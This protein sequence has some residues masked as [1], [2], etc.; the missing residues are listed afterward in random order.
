MCTWM[1]A[2]QPHLMLVQETHWTEA[3]EFEQGSYR[4]ISSGGT[5]RC[6]G[7]LLAVHSKLASPSHI[8]YNEWIPGRLLHVRVKL[9]L[10]TWDIINVYQVPWRREDSAEKNVRNRKPVWK[11]LEALLSSLPHRNGLLIGGDFNTVLP[12]DNIITGPRFYTPDRPETDA[13]QFH[14]LCTLYSLVA[15]NTHTGHCPTYTS[16]QGNSVIDYLLTRGPQAGHARPRT[17]V[18]PVPIGDW[19]G[20]GKHLMLRTQLQAHTWRYRERQTP[21]LAKWDE[22]AL[23]HATTQNTHESQCWAANM[24]TI[25]T[26]TD[27]RSAL[28]QALSALTAQHFPRAARQSSS[29]PWQTCQVRQSIRRLWQARAAL[30][31]LDT[32]TDLASIFRYWKHSAAVAACSRDCKRAGRQARK[33]KLLRAIDEAEQAK[34]QGDLRG[35]YQVVKRLAPKQTHQRVQLRSPAGMMLN[36]EEGLQALIKYGKSTFCREPRETVSFPLSAPLHISLEDLQQ[37]LCALKPN[38][39]VP[40]NSAPVSAFQAGGDMLLPTLLQHLQRAWRPGLEPKLDRS[41]SS[42]W[43]VWIPKPGKSPTRPEHLRPLALMT[44]EAKLIATLLKHKLQPYVTTFLLDTPQFAYTSNRNIYH[45]LAKVLGHCR[46]VRE[47]TQAYTESIQRR[48]DGTCK[49]AGGSGFG[50]LQLALD[51]SKAFEAV[52]QPLQA[53]VLSL[54][55]STKY[56]VSSGAAQ[57]TLHTSNGIRQGCPLS[58]LLWSLASGWLWKTL[59]QHMTAEGLKGL[60]LYADDHHFGLTFHD[61]K[62]L[63]AAIKQ[64]GVL[65]AVLRDA[66]LDVNAQKSVALLEVRGRALRKAA[67]QCQGRSPTGPYLRIPNPNNPTGKVDCIPLHTTAVYLGVVISYKN[68]ED[69]TVRRNIRKAQH[70]YHQ[71]RKLLNGHHSLTQHTRLRLWRA[72]LEPIFYYALHV[73]GVTKSGSRLLHTALVK[74]LRAVCASPVHIT[75]ESTADLLGR[76]GVAWYYDTLALRGNTLATKLAQ[77]PKEDTVLQDPAIAAQITHAISTF[78]QAMREFVQETDEARHCC[79]VCGAAFT[80]NSGLKTHQRRKHA[81][82]PVQSTLRARDIGLNGLPTCSFCKTAF[83]KWQV[84][85]QHVRLL[86]CEGLRSFWKMESVNH[87]QP[88][89]PS[90]TYPT[91]THVLEFPVFLNKFPQAKQ[92]LMQP[93]ANAWGDLFR[94]A[95]VAAWLRQHCPI[96]GQWIAGSPGFKHHWRRIHQDIWEAISALTLKM[97]KRSSQYFAPMAG[98]ACLACCLTVKQPRSHVQTCA[99]VFQAVALQILVNPES[100]RQPSHVQHGYRRALAVRGWT[101]GDMGRYVSL[102]TSTSG[103][104]SYQHHDDARAKETTGA[105]RVPPDPTSSCAREAAHGLP[106]CPAPHVL[107][108]AR[109]AHSHQPGL[110]EAHAPAGGFPPDDTSRPRLCPSFGGG[111]G[112]CSV[113]EALVKVSQKWHATHQAHQTSSTGNDPG[114]SALASLTSS[115]TQP[116]V[117]LRTLLMRCLIK[118]MLTRLTTFTQTSELQNKATETGLF[119]ASTE[120][121]AGAGAWTMMRW[122]PDTQKMIPDSCR[123]A[124]STDQTVKILQS[125]EADLMDTTLVLRFHS[126][127]KWHEIQRQRKAVML[128]E[129]SNRKS[130]LHS[131]LLALCGHPALSMIDASLKPEGMRRS[132][133]AQ[134]LSKMIA[135]YEQQMGAAPRRWG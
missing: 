18:T 65:L 17:T 54:L 129:V 56:V 118:E 63:A 26:N 34:H 94:D 119:K 19:R 110:S 90:T 105:G 77:A 98:H 67:K 135:Q 130:S 13:E 22:R 73:V 115:A 83:P 15:L 25:E 70:R 122:C 5:E 125:L 76:T 16:P 64:A 81:V 71:L 14:S 28:D 133:M 104:S 79:D 88:P 66:G 116:Q 30:L 89:S 85:E 113:L 103:R 27:D 60:T 109:P 114:E 50:A 23:R 43:L 11:Q 96:C 4:M 10:Q 61:T 82:R 40:P 8:S 84:L 9:K 49:S 121:G 45:S 69:A 92:I 51:L 44:G 35:L 59:S 102:G 46:F 86:A 126:L 123:P 132:P 75:R 7:L 53:V 37:A 41:W 3:R 2:A 58:P 111:G 21:T 128:I 99:V 127:K 80:T 101:C 95:S 42:G 107:S 78:T 120:A 36:D 6:S 52:P 55:R 112:G 87:N 97:H 33:Q 93:H 91:H 131:G 12:R 124:C 100:T 31:R 29:S 117:P 32:P 72:C 24:E 108:A 47:Q 57:Q 1:S 68:F 39:A 38:K 134:R 106:V 74:Q 20:G 48:H 62:G